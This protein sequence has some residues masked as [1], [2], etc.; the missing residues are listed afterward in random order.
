MKFFVHSKIDLLLI[1]LLAVFL[2]GGGRAKADFIFGTP[3]NLGSTVNSSYGDWDPSISGDGLTLY[4]GSDRLGGSGFVD[5]WVTTRPTTSD[6]W[7][8]P[9]NLGAPVNTSAQ[10]FGPSISA[11]DLQLYFSSNRLGGSGDIDL[12][13]TTR[14]TTSD[15]WGPPVNLGS[16]VNSSYS[17]HS[18]DISADGLSLYF[19]DWPN[20]RPGGFGN[21]DL[22]VTMRQTKSNPW[23]SPVNFGL[24]VNSSA[25]DGAPS[26]S[27][28]GL[29]FFFDSTRF[30][31]QGDGDIWVT[32]RKT[33]TDPWGTPV[34]L[35]SSVN[36]SVWD[37]TPDIS[38]DGSTL[39]F[40]SNRTGGS[41][42]NDLWQVPITPQVDFN[43]DWV[44]NVRDF[45]KL[46]I[47]WSQDESSVDIAPLPL[48]DSKVDFKDLKVLLEYWLK[49]IRLAFNPIPP[50]GADHVDPNIVLSWSPGATADSHVIYFG[51]SFEDVNN[52]DPY[53]PEFRT[54]QFGTSWDPC[55]IDPLQFE[56]TYF[57]RIDEVDTDL[58]TMHKGDTWNFTTESSPI[59]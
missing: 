20:Q 18:P 33:T 32:T 13:V 55:D 53:S 10:D 39:Y 22:W 6:P 45:C 27:A 2:A 38:G 42:D 44:T 59:P 57:W 40:S 9:V 29:A 46:A 30:G 36:S 11:D 1:G 24:T 21:D 52:A 19:C 56:E 17:E 7:G 35:G 8:L 15:P 16:T 58:A 43:G 50:H 3:T 41:G 48:G 28:D 4:L 25:G 14:P 26:I 31:G 23:A 12:Y 5:I 37:V 47:Y 34:N 49:D 51:D 54:V